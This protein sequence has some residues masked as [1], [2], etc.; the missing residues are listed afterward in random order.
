[1]ITITRRTLAGLAS[2]LCAS[3]ILPARAAALEATLYKN[4][5]CGCCEGYAAYLRQHGFAVTVVPTN[6]L[7]EMSRKAGIPD[8]L[9]GC[10]L[11]QVS[12]YAIGGHVPIATVRKLLAQRPAD[13]IAITLPGMPQGA[14]G[15]S[16][17]KEG[18]FKVYAIHKDGAAP[19]V[20]DTV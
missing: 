20:F 13:I 16:G 5:Q 10:H 12:G 19:S 8:A 17:S 14:P 18:P 7:D 11:T 4:P 3:L 9:E 2:A 1:M 15:M 6:D